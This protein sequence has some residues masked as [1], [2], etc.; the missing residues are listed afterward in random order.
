MPTKKYV[1]NADTYYKIEGESYDKMTVTRYYKEQ[2][3]SKLYVGKNNGAYNVK[4]N[5][6]YESYLSKYPLTES[7]IEAGQTAD[8]FGREYRQINDKTV[9]FFMDTHENNKIIGIFADDMNVDFMLTS[10]DPTVDWQKANV[11][12]MELLFLEVTNAVCAN[13]GLPPVAYH[14][15]AAAVSRQHAIDLL[16]HNI[17]GHTGSDG[18]TPWDRMDRSNVTDFVALSEIVA[19]DSDPI[20]PTFGFLNSKAGHRDALLSNVNV[21]APGYA[22]KSHEE[23][24]GISAITSV[25][26]GTMPSNN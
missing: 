16:S 14:K 4:I 20:G 9:L 12:D 3:I 1:V 6:S 19:G 2:P 15:A 24:I 5:E 22:I 17:F 23:Y 7:L 26:T 21:F 8:N 13:Y 25:Y 10:Y 11:V 18:S